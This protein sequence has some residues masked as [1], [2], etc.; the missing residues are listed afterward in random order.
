FSVQLFAAFAVHAV[1]ALVHNLP[2]NGLQN[3]RV[4]VIIDVYHAVETADYREL[5]ACAVFARRFDGQALAWLHI[6]REAFDIERLAAGDAERFPAGA[7]SELQRQN[8][9]ANEVAAVNPLEAF[10]DDRFDAEQVRTL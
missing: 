4:A 7:V 9:H 8:A 5:E 6:V 2:Q 1:R 3:A 10:S